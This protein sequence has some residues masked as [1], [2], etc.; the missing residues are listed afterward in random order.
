MFQ[1]DCKVLAPLIQCLS[2]ISNEL[3]C[4]INEDGCIISSCDQ[5]R[6]VYAECKLSASVVTMIDNSE[7]MSFIASSI[8][9]YQIIQHFTTIYLEITSDFIHFKTLLKDT[10]FSIPQLNSEKLSLDYNKL[11]L[12]GMVKVLPHINWNLLLKSTFL[13]FKAS[14][15]DIELVTT[16]NKMETKLTI[17]PHD[18]DSFEYT[19]LE[20][21]VPLAI[22]LNVM[23]IGQN[24]KKPVV[25]Y[26]QRNE[27][28]VLSIGITDAYELD[29]V[30]SIN[31][32]T[33][34]L[35][36]NDCDSTTAI[37]DTLPLPSTT[38]PPRPL[39]RMKYE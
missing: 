37:S 16:L 1:L 9:F 12:S 32:E 19:E 2:K 20:C 25:W 6:I 15:Q 17:N 7:Y 10:V 39:K 34:L 29:V 38:Q 4:I 28:M 31:E 30:V 35:Y 27:P 13:K 14:Q 36:P 18:C 5:N 3:C 11:N 26:F 23:Q 33:N 22:I 8:P 24:A 21:I